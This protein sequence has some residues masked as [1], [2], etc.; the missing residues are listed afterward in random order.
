[1]RALNK[2]VFINSA[3]IRYAEVAIDGNVHFT[4]TQGV[5]KT[6]LLRA[7][8]FFYNCRKDKLGIRTQG[9]Q[10]F[11]DF[12]IPTP[13]S[14]I[15]YEV[16]R[17]ENESPFSIIL[18]R[19]HNRAAFR[20][21]DA[22]YSK[23]WF[24]DELGVV[25]SDQ[26][27]VRQRIQNLGIDLSS[28]VERYTQY[29]DI[30]YGNRSAHPSKDL[31]KYYLL[32][33]QQY[34]TIPRIIQNVFLN[35]RVDAGFIKNII[36][37]SITGDD[38]E[39]AVDLNFF[40]S[41]L[42]HFNEELQDI[43]LWSV[44]TR[45]GIKTRQD[46]DEIISNSHEIKATKHNLYEQCGML[47]YAVNR[48]SRRIP[49]LK[50]RIANKEETIRQIN[51]K[52]EELKSKYEKEL[53][54]IDGQ[55]AVLSNDLKKA[56][57]LKKQ[58]QS[59]DIEEMIARA[60]QL[61]SLKLELQ[62]KERL[63]AQLTSNYQSI[64]DKYANLRDRLNL[65]KDQ[66]LQRLKERRNTINSDFNSR[67][68]ER[69]EEK[70]KLESDIRNKFKALTAELDEK[71]NSYRD[72]LHDLEVQRVKASTSSPRKEDV[73]ACANNIAETEKK[74]HELSE[75]K[76]REEN[77]L[78]TIRNRFELE[79]QQLEADTALH[80]NE[81]E[82]QISQLEK[83]RAEQQQILDSAQGSLCEWL[84]HNVAGWENTIGKIADEK[85]V[86]YSQNLNPRRINSNVDT[87]F[88]V[89]LDVDAIE[90]EVRTPTM[91]Q[92]AITIID[93]EIQ[94]LA[95]DIIK[96]RQEKDVRIQ[97]RGKEIRSQQKSIQA[98]IY[99][100]VLSIKVCR[101]QVKEESLRLD[102]IKE[103]E[104]KQ[105]EEITSALNDR[106]QELQVQVDNLIKERSAIDNECNSQLRR[107]NKSFI[108]KEK[109][110]KTQRDE[111]L[112][113]IDD[114]FTE[115]IEKHKAKLK[116]LEIDEATEL[117]NSGADTTMLASIKNEITELKTSINNIDKE[118]ET[119]AIYRNDC[120]NL[121]NHVTQKQVD[122]KKLED[123]RSR[124]REKY[125][126][127]DKRL[128]GKKEEE[129]NELSAMRLENDN[130]AASIRLAEE[131][132]A[133]SA[134]PPE[135]KESN[136]VA[137]EFDCTAIISNIQRLMVEIHRLSDA[138]KENINEFRK[139]FSPNNTFKFPTLFDTIEDYHRFAES[140]EDFVINNKIKD[141]QQ[142]T[143]NLYCDILSRA[144]TDFNILLGRESEIGRIVKAINLDF[145]KKTFAGVIRS[146]ELRLDRS[147]MPIITQLQNITSF[148]NEHQYELGAINLFSTDEHSDINRESIKYLKS[149]S[150]ALSH[151]S[152][153]KKL[154][155]EQTFTLRFRISENDNTTDWVENIR[156][157][158]S[159]G[160]DILVKAIIN[161]LL[162]SVFKKRASQTGDFKLHCMMDE[163]GRLADENIQGILNFANQRGIYI[164]N[165]SPKAHRPLSYRR[166]Y[167]LSKD[168]KANTTV[169]P[170]LSTREAE[171][172]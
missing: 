48:I 34:Q 136:S 13:S 111:L 63:L 157:V 4:G 89:A 15:I 69:L 138:L 52:I 11:D 127:R 101:Q 133:S 23:N 9:Q 97:E 6:T 96:I 8:L 73:T 147:T 84:D 141:F 61:P 106:I 91:I 86:L 85:S 148:W 150:T 171:L 93:K 165:S 37:N 14:Y 126:E 152:E 88:G 79:S 10:P 135:I 77:H 18:F 145:E 32:R 155:L 3:H 7:L 12:Y 1:M 16:S 130:N 42:T 45:Q 140:L 170:I 159:E 108:D 114:T 82:N 164:V 118:R 125:D 70:T 35:E 62:Q 105:I 132:I 166:L 38:E 160:T 44:G 129:E 162:I 104:K 98:D 81:L 41:K 58:Y 56:S 168:N 22:P 72:L 172:R 49:I 80:I 107:V 75:K 94:D 139:R 83:Q 153:I 74:E 110:D 146:I 39:I 90:K 27:T 92:E 2:I 102:T 29:L 66:Y 116:Q 149:L 19:H 119:I 137:T 53:Q 78:Q 64:S 120:K 144:A 113:T 117:S 25:A 151:A 26:I 142:V 28:I 33:S 124:L 51:E 112:R 59:M 123:D 99:N 143:N 95:N 21:V 128:K 100:I 55:I 76:L 121:L 103:E 36:I 167:M 65:D 20:F 158:G 169:Q 5:G 163:I 134:C 67:K 156:A 17:G 24:I 68:A 31:L 154:P 161:I 50:S 47:N 87:V 122:K 57:E 43:S 46:A 109:A 71:I 40:R 60:G 131:F 54:K 115:Y 30:L